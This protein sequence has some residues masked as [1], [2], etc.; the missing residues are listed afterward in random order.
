MAR[1]TTTNLAAILVAFLRFL[2]ALFDGLSGGVGRRR[3][4]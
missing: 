1:L 2:F 4:D 3:P